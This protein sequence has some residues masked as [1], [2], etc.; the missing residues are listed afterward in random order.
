MRFPSRVKNIRGSNPHDEALRLAGA[1]QLAR[2]PPVRV[3]MASYSG[4]AIRRCRSVA[5]R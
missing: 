5:L 4:C 2:L 1:L 3:P